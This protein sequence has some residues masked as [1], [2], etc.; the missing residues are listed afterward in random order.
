MSG[1]ERG[2]VPPD[3]AAAATL[4]E[5]IPLCSSG[6]I[7]DYHLTAYDFSNYGWA[8]ATDFSSALEILPGLAAI[9]AQEHHPRAFFLSS[10]MEQDT[11]TTWSVFQQPNQ[12]PNC[13]QQAESGKS[14]QDQ[15]A[16]MMSELMMALVIYTTHEKKHD[17]TNAEQLLWILEHAEHRVCGYSYN[18][19]GLVCVG[20]GYLSLSC[21]GKLFFTTL[22]H[23]RR[24][25]TWLHQ[26]LVILPPVHC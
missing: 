23:H 3:A 15:P 11:A 20:R 7:D 17:T 4:F 1:R 5:P 6:L 2:D 26:L 24:E 21:F 18:E 19:D 13:H 25:S 10:G 8:E 12:Q 9:P 16:A 22:L 14:Q